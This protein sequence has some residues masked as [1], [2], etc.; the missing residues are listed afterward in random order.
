MENSQFAEME[1]KEMECEDKDWNNLA[2]DRVLWWDLVN[3]TIH[4][5]VRNKPVV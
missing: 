2:E 5:P 3:T 4:L 1:L